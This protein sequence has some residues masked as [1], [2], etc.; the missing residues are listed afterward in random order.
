LTPS[1]SPPRPRP[2]RRPRASSSSKDSGS[3]RGTYIRIGHSKK[4]KRIELHKGMTFAVGR[5]HFKVQSIE[6]AAADNLEAKKKQEEEEAKAAKAKAEGKSSGKEEE[7]DS[8][9]EYAD[10]SDDDKST[11]T[12]SGSRKGKLDGPPVM[13]LASLDKKNHSIKG[14]IRETSTI[15]TDKEK[16][17]IAISAEL[18]KEKMV[19]AVHTRICLEDGHFY[20]E[21]ANSSF[22]TWVGLIKKCFFEVHVGDHI[23]LGSARCRI[24]M[25]VVP[26]QPIQG[27]IDILL[28]NMNP[29]NY[30]FKLLGSSS[31]YEERLDASRTRG[32]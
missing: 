3:R 7:L 23:M 30:S 5:V 19:D 9:E 1:A 26:L 12:T 24:G 6:G 10:D 28:G 2:R 29:A 15:G 17:K 18:G 8:D 20:L 21:D 25:N 16:N 27:I 13:F 14:R 31:S 4:N 11:S 22:G 32:K